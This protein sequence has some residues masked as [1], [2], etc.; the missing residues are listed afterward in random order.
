VVEYVLEN[1]EYFFP[2]P[3][4]TGSPATKQTSPL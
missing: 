1:M 2:A 4:N 3:S